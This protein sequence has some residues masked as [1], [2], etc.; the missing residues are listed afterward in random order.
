[1]AA[2]FSMSAGARLT[3]MRFGG[4]ARPMAPMALR[5]RTRDSPTALS[6]RPT[7]VK[8]GR[9]DE[10]LTCTSTSSASMP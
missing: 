7:M 10:M 3:V 1:M 8:L 2:F 4:S 5:T 6:G 9:P